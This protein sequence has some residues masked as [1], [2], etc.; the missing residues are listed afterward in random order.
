[1]PAA[2]NLPVPVTS[3]SVV[4]LPTVMAAT[5]TTA[6]PPAAPPVALL[7]MAL[8]EVAVTSRSPALLMAPAPVVVS[9]INAWV[10]SSITLIET[11]APIPRLLPTPPPLAG[12]A[13][14]VS[15]LLLKAVTMTAPV[16]VVVRFAPLLT[17]AVVIKCPTLMASDPAAPTLAPGP[18]PPEVDF[19]VKP[20]DPVA[21]VL[22]D[23]VMAVPLNVAPAPTKAVLVTLPTL[24]ATAAPIP[25][26]LPLPLPLLL[27]LPI[28]AVP[29]AV[30][31]AVVFA[32]E[33]TEIAPAV[34]VTLV[35]GAIVAEVLVCARLTA[36][37]AATST[38][39]EPLEE[40]LVLAVCAAGVLPEPLVRAPAPPAAASPL[41]RSPAT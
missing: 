24:I 13:V 38:G 37:A 28:T 35:F 8:V 2:A 17:C 12:T 14:A 30:A 11:E 39:E 3:A 41:P 18:P 9:W 15:E 29:S 32:A 34:A 21:G 6:T 33:V 19:A 4:R 31:E 40:P 20:S 23:T 22:A 16:P 27:P 5:G 1:M 25:T 7:V 26:P 10:V 36:T